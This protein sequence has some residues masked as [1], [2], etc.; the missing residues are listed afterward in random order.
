MYVLYVVLKTSPSHGLGSE[1]QDS[2]VTIWSQSHKCYFLAVTK[3]SQPLS[4]SSSHYL[5]PRTVQLYGAPFTFAVTINLNSMTVFWQ[6]AVHVLKKGQQKD[7]V[8]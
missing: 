6:R 5:G 1:A 3:L 7:R 2:E 4:V 8:D